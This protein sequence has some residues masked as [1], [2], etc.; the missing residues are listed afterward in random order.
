MY[1]CGICKDKS[2]RIEKKENLPK[3]CPIL[4]TN[5]EEILG[6]YQEPEN[7]KL[8]YNSAIGEAEGYCKRTRMEEIIEFAKRCEFKNIGIAFCAGLSNETK[9]LHK[10]LNA[11]GFEINSVIC[12]NGSIPKEHLSIKEN[13]KVRPGTY[14]P[15]CNP[16]GQAQFLNKANTDLNIILGLC[17]GHDSL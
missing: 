14:E 4:E 13:E 7:L 10:I 8:A 9:I 16:I 12:K 2:C 1:S 3:N 11:H 15:M 6:Y 5:L 17:V